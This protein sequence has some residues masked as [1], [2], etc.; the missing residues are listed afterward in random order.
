MSS[1]SFITTFQDI[2][3]EV[4]ARSN[5]TSVSPLITPTIIQR[6][7]NNSYA[8]AGRLFK[9]PALK[10]AKT[11]SSK[12]GVPNYDY[13]PT[14]QPESIFRVEVAGLDDPVYRRKDFEDYLDWI[15][16]NP[17]DTDEQIFANYWTQF[18]LF[19][20][21][22]TNGSNDI[23]VWGYQ[24]VT[25]LVLTTDTTIFSNVD[26]LGNEAIAKQALSIC[27]AIAEGKNV[28]LVENEEA[29]AILSL[30]FSKISEDKQNDQRLDHPMFRIPD[31]FAGAT[32]ATE[33]GGFNI[34]VKD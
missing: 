23:S 6:E 15:Q 2:I 5:S 4:Q 27:Q 12:A 9:W 16:N 1:T 10:A 14:F 22:N 28:A 26:P 20:V 24:Q 21:L 18:F 31:Y 17:T 8:W 13:P 11:T 34:V 25:P 3:D 29:K 7:I 32:Q 33:K 19:P 30:I